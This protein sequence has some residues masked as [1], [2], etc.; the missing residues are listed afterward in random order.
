M[1]TSLTVCA[2]GAITKSDAYCHLQS[3]VHSELWLGVM[4]EHTGS[5][6][7]VGT[8]LEPATLPCTIQ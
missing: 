1:N 6:G 5:I 7:T 2:Q 8:T 3:K 4:A